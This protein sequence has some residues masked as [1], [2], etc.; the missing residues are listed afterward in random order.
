M[1]ARNYKSMLRKSGLLAVVAGAGLSL[2]AATGCDLRA[3]QLAALPA[4]SVLTDT[5]GIIDM[6][7]AASPGKASTRMSGIINIGP[8]H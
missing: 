8:L 6:H 7:D 5:S 2:L 4:A 3:E 1:S